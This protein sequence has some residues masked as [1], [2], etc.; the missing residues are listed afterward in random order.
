MQQIASK[1]HFD[2]QTLI[3][4]NSEACTPLFSHAACVLPHIQAAINIAIS[5]TRILHPHFFLYS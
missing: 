3:I 4:I 1:E 5:H 2:L